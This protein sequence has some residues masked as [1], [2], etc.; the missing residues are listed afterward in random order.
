MPASRSESY[1]IAGNFRGVL[2]FVIFVTAVAFKKFCTP[3][4]FAAVGK[5]RQAKSRRDRHRTHGSISGISVLLTL[6]VSLTIECRIKLPKLE[7]S[8]F[9]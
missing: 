4:K 5:G 2:I 1:R 9:M 6:T 7:I 3:R 8:L